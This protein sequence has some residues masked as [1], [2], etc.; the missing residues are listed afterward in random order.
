MT[1]PF[2]HFERSAKANPKKIAVVSTDTSLSYAE[3]FDTV[4]RF[5]KALRARGVQPGKYVGTR[6]SPILDLVVSE[7]LFHES[8]VGAQIPVGHISLINSTFDLLVVDEFIAGFPVENQ[9]LIDQAFLDQVA[10]SVAVANPIL[11]KNKHELCR[12]SFS[13]GTTGEPKVIPVSIDCLEDRSLDRTHQWM[14]QHPY[15]CLLGLST[16][17]TFMSF[18]WH[19]FAGETFVLT[20]TTKQLPQQIVEHKIAC[21]MGS[22]HQLG[23][24]IAELEKT[25]DAFESLQT[26]MSAGSVLPDAIYER[27]EKRLGVKVITTYASSEAGSVAK[28]DGKGSFEGYAGELFEDVEVKILGEDFQPVAD[29]VIGAVAINR[30]RQ[31][32]Y[33]LND[34]ETSVKTFINGFFLPGDLGYLKGNQLFIVGRSAE[35]INAAGVKV[36]PA[37]VDSVAREF[38]GISDAA[39][40]AITGENQLESIA[41]VFVSENKIDAAEFSRYLAARLGESA[42]SKLLRVEGIPRNH[43]GKVNRSGLAELFNETKEAAFSNSLD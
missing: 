30:P 37:V 23:D 17:L 21:I 29:E 41:L 9:I 5:A 39:T 31:P 25:S 22:P 18:Y 28:R 16:G 26:V 4:I 2:L 38:F 36:D 7:A 10:Q 13:S 12:L 24:L 15:L 20:G 43:M 11:Y 33:Y 19:M 35:I 34:P 1:Q 3:L 8:A 6:L 32:K 14:P 40:F 42:P 27:F